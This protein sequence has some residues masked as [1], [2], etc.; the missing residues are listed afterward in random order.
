MKRK[1]PRKLLWFDLPRGATIP[2][3]VPAPAEIVR[4]W[5]VVKLRQGELFTGVIRSAKLF[6]CFAHYLPQSH[7]YAPCL[8]EAGVA[9]EMCEGLPKRYLAALAMYTV[10]IPHEPCLLCLPRMAIRETPDLELCTGAALVGRQL[11][12]RRGPFAKSRVHLVLT[13]DKKLDIPEDKWVQPGEV[14]AQLLLVWGVRYRENG[15]LPEQAA[16]AVP[17]PEDYEAPEDLRDAPEE[18]G[19]P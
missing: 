9:C 12:A 5:R 10:S 2:L 11:T 7:T 1:Q 16:A 4:F 14:L 3:S 18:E 19:T 17:R 6:A 13:S 8:A 15:Q